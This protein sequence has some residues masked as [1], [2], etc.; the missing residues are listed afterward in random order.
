MRDI[1]A[2]MDQ[3]MTTQARASTVQA[4]TMTD[5]ANRDVAPRPNQQVTTM[6]SHLRDFTQMNPPAIYGSKV[7][8]DPQKLHD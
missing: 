6:A 3:A 5:Q 4:Q 1:L 8:E 7:D 2:Q